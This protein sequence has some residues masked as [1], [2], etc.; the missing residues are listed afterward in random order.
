MEYRVHETAKILAA[1]LVLRA[2]LRGE[3]SSMMDMG[4]SRSIEGFD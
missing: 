3:S 4:R 2:S 1:G